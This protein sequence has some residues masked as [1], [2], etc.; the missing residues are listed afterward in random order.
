MQP[1]GSPTSCSVLT[2]LPRF[3]WLE[4]RDRR[5]GRQLRPVQDRTGGGS[6]PSDILLV[7]CLRNE[8]PRMPAFADHYRRL[9]VGH[10][11]VVDND[12]TD[13]LMDW[14]AA[15]PDVSVWHTAASYRDIDASACSGSTTCCAAT[16]CGRWCVVVDP[17]EFLVY[18]QHGDPLAAGARASSS[19]TTT[20]PACT[21][22]SSTPT[23]TGRW[24]RRH[25][26][27][28]DDPFA[29]CPFFDRDGYLQR[30]SWGNSTWVQ[31]GPRM[32][33]HFADR[34]DGGAGAEQD[35]V[36]ALEAATTTTTCRPTT[37]GRG[38]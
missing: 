1:R 26:G 16:A 36:G 4:L 35:P 2:S 11:L 13:G 5:A 32:R 25:L 34:P 24:P 8:R 14:A 12:S 15:Q 7:T 37:P 33:V 21:R 3:V 18:P 17:D 9:G 27:E 23:A 20:G 29:V 19:R 30:E 6:R 10:F 31:G 22:C 38:G 28:G